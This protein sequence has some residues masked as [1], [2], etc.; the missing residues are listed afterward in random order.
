MASGMVLRLPRAN[1]DRDMEV[2][3]QGE[4]LSEKQGLRRNE[5]QTIG[6]VC[7]DL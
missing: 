5:A 2:L 4:G 6:L 3:L 7:L 1:L